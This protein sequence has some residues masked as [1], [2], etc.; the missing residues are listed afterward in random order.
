M[1]IP[2]FVSVAAKLND[3]QVHIRD[4]LFS[5]LRHNLNLD[6][7]TVGQSDYPSTSPLR[8]VLVLARHC[9]GAV[10]LGFTEVEA[11][12]VGDDTGK[13][14][15]LTTPWNQLE[16]GITHA[17]GLP[18]LVFRQKGVGGGIFD[19]GASGLF[20][21]ELPSPAEWQAREAGVKEV[22]MQWRSLVQ[23]HYYAGE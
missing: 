19:V 18:M 12:P 5:E 7:R 10:V 16:S 1:Q 15:S 8:E 14:L 23:Q 9:A 17:L 11:T 3:D 6:P 13:V 21:H 2:V 22:L 4:K 20:I